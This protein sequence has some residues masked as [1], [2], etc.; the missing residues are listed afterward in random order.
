MTPEGDLVFKKYTKGTVHVLEY[1]VNVIKAEVQEDRPT[2]KSVMVQGE[3]A[4]SFKGADSWPWLTKKEVS[5]TKEGPSSTGAEILVQDASIKETGAAGDMAGA[6]M[7][8]A[9]RTFSGT[10]KIVGDAGIKLGET[11]EIKGMSN[12]K[13]NGEFQVRS[14]EHCISKASGFTT[15]IGWSK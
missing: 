11:V 3:S 15:Q 4:S 6:L 13:M 2:V 8:N 7:E 10:I 9:S 5:G 14:V 12:S 1:G